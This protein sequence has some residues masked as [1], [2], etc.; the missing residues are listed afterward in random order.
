MAGSES[1][2]R[3]IMF[4][5]PLSKAVGLER[6]IRNIMFL[7]SLLDLAVEFKIIYFDCL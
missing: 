5:I 3:D 2:T 4:L 1:D 7:V 6:D